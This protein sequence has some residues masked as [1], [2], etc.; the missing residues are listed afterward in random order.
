MTSEWGKALGA[1]EDKPV[2]TK[3]STKTKN[4]MIA[5]IYNFNKSIEYP[6]NS[7]VNA[8]ALSKVFKSLRD[9]GASYDDLHG[10][11]D[12]FF[13]EIKQKPLPYDV[14]TWTAFIKRRDSLLQWVTQ[15]KPDSDVSE[16]K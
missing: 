4:T 2:V 6:M 14:P 12:R 10:M 1:D 9:S 3:M 7:E 5:L 15:N 11:I 13:Y 8:L 16:W